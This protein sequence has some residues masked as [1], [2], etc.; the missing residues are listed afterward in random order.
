[1]NLSPVAW[2]FGRLQAAPFY[3]DAHE[4]AVALVR[5]PQSGGPWL[6]VGAGPGL[7]ARLAVARGYDPV[8]AADASAAMV[9]SA[10]RQAARDA[11]RVTCRRASL[12]DLV[13][14][15]SRWAV[16]SAASLIAVLSDPEAGLNALWS[17][18]APGGQLLL[19]EPTDAMRPQGV[20]ALRSTLPGPEARWL[21]DT[22]ARARAGRSR[23]DTV[24][25]FHPEDE[26]RR[27]RVLLLDGALAA[28]CLDRA[29][30]QE[31]G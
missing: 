25:R 21:L 26:A 2:L 6:D 11:A 17:L 12:E 15:D 29:V 28:W 4:R 30:A 7:V 18:V 24:D 14:E 23:A 10:R 9:D 31:G 19:V 8:V 16:V 13:A 1:V 3:R 5:T 27:T 22:W 20:A